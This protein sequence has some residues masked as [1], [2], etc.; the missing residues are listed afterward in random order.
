MKQQCSWARFSVL[1]GLLA[2]LLASAAWATTVTGGPVATHQTTPSV[3]TSWFAACAAQNLPTT[4][5]VIDSNIMIFEANNGSGTP[6][7]VEYDGLSGIGHGSPDTGLNRI[8]GRL[9][10]SYGYNTTLDDPH[11]HPNNPPASTGV[12]FKVRT[13]FGTGGVIS[14][15]LDTAQVTSGCS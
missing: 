12:L 6:G 15:S 7:W 4:E 1:T 3:H 5:D 2:A 11:H 10:T 8:P 14:Y 13:Y 9:G